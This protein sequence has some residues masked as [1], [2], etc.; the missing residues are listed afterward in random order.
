MFANFSLVEARE[1][2]AVLALMARKPALKHLAGEIEERESAI[3]LLQELDE[4]ADRLFSVEGKGVTLDQMEDYII[5]LEDEG[6]DVVTVLDTSYP[7]NLR[8]V[9][10]RPPALF[11]RGSLEEADERSVAVVG[12]RKA[13]ERGLAQA[14]AVADALLEAD[15]TIVSGLAEGIDSAAH[16][17]ALDAG[18]R[19]VAVIG[20]GQKHSFPAKNAELQNTIAEQ[21]AVVSHL[22]PN[23]GPRK[24]TFPLR[25]AVMS[26]FARATVVVEASDTSGARGQAR[27]ARE[28][29][30][31]VFLLE[32]LLEHEWARHAATYPNV[33]IVKDC[34]QITG[35][36]ERLYDSQSQLALVP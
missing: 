12:T 3:R 19:T 4:P 27:L 24:W 13:S 5:S 15:Y 17:R 8:M 16:R 29:G 31:P 20:T 23:Q 7:A 21:S 35:N 34:D 25:N 6:I 28:H 2:A 33:Y 11:V 30:R 32:S 26:G 36:L 10:D 9:Y 1:R 18:A 22:W 14:R